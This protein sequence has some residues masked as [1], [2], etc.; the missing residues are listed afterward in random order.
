MNSSTRTTCTS[1]S[2]STREATHAGSWYTNKPKALNEELQSYLNQAQLSSHIIND[3][4]ND[5]ELN[6]TS[7][8]TSDIDG[9]MM[10]V[11]V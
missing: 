6:S 5:I 4:D 3:H 8:S 1:N 2:T 11:S 9:I 10:C 7:T